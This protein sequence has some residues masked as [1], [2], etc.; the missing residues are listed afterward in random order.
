MACAA[1]HKLIFGICLIRAAQLAHSLGSSFV[2]T[3]A[4]PAVLSSLKH[5]AVLN[6]T[7][8]QHVTF[9][10]HGSASLSAELT[11]LTSLA[12]FEVTTTGESKRTDF[13]HIRWKAM[14]KLQSFKIAGPAVFDKH[15]ADVILLPCKCGH[16]HDHKMRDKAAVLCICISTVQCRSGKDPSNYAQTTAAAGLVTTMV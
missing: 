10:F 13:I 9:T 3:F 12:L 11:Q 16:D 1:L 6:M 7:S 15:I 8:L 14:Q 5:L 2:G 4:V